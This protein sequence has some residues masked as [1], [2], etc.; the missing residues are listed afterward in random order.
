MQLI[1]NNKREYSLVNLNENLHLK[2]INTFK[3]HTQNMNPTNNT[4]ISWI[5]KITYNFVPNFTSARLAETLILFDL[6]VLFEN[7][8]NIFLKNKINK[9]LV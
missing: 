3:N 9:Q 2:L 4:D 7:L 8:I 6:A 5:Y 1:K